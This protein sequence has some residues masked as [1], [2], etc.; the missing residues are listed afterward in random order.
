[1][2]E[3]NLTVNCEAMLI[4]TRF[5]RFC[6]GL[7][8]FY[9]ALL[10]T[11]E[12]YVKAGAAP[13]LSWLKI[14]FHVAERE[15][16]PAAAIADRLRVDAR[17]GK[18][19]EVKVSSANTGALKRLQELVGELDRVR[20]GLRSGDEKV[21]LQAIAGDQ[22]VDALLLAPLRSIL[23][24]NAIPSDGVDA[25]LS[26]IHRG[27]LAVCDNLIASIETAWS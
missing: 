3:L 14:G 23:T 12:P 5:F 20:R 11:S 24:R 2:A 15:A 27:L 9:Y 18:I 22:K 16:P 26:M 21:R 7:E 25:F 1:V 6:K 4:S 19:F 8:H 13:W 17:P 10:F